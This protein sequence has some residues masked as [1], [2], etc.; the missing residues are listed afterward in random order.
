MSKDLIKSA[1]IIAFFAFTLSTIN[2]VIGNKI[3][4]G[5]FQ[6]IRVN[7]TPKMDGDFPS[8]PKIERIAINPM[9]SP[10]EETKEEKIIHLNLL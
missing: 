9:P 8:K 3:I 7:A 4:K 2:P 10:I 6:R 1:N 5:I